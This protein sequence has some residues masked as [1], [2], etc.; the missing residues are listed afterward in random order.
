MNRP[1]L[2][3]LAQDKANHLIYGLLAFL[4]AAAV[5]LRTGHGQVAAIQHGLLFG[6]AIAVLWELF[7]KATKTGEPSPADAIATSS[8]AGLGALAMGLPLLVSKFV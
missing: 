5:S 8:G 6:I 4:V 2:P 7:Q 1:N 3:Q